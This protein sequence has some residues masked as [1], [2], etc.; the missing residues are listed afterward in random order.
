[1]ELINLFITNNIK[2]V[3][4]FISQYSS[5]SDDRKAL[6]ER[7]LGIDLDH[8]DESVFNIDK[9]ELTGKKSLTKL[10]LDT[11]LGIIGMKLK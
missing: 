3:H 10:A 5:N 7:L 1:M 2:E 11:Y 4:R 9:V 8:Y 6:A